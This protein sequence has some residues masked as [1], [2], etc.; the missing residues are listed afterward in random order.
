MNLP[1]LLYR[2]GVHFS[3]PL[4]LGWPCDLLWPA[5]HGGTDAAWIPE[6]R[7]QEDLK[8]PPLP[9][10]NTVLR[11]P[12][13]GE[14]QEERPHGRG[15]GSQP[16]TLAWVSP[17][18]ANRSIQPIYWV[19]G[20]DTMVTFSLKGLGWLVIQQEIRDTGTLTGVY[21]VLETHFKNY[22]KLL[23]LKNRQK[24]GC[25][26]LATVVTLREEGWGG[27]FMGCW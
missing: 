17:A 22:L 25:W 3:T 21:F 8:L 7:P 18:E 12:F 20:I 6:P 11:L 14:A 27:S 15:L 9:S 5:E 10:W 26:N 4:N 23:K 2:S 19:A 24:L 1:F 16:D 13:H